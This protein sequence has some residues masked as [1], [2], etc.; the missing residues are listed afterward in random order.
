MTA[1][2]QGEVLRTHSAGLLRRRVSAGPS[3]SGPG[4]R[5]G[6]E[7]RTADMRL[8][9]SR[10]ALR[11]HCPQLGPPSWLRPVLSESATPNPSPGPHRRSSVPSTVQPPPG[12]RAG[13]RIR[14][15]AADA[16]PRRKA[17]LRL[18]FCAPARRDSAA[19]LARQVRLGSSGPPG[20]DS[21][22]AI[23]RLTGTKSSESSFG[24]RWPAELP[25]RTWSPAAPPAPS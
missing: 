6:V 15:S 18:P 14:G 4:C 22:A 1:R 10:T 11:R 13:P 17:A 2:P 25:S 24:P 7:P 23:A 21:E 20:L 16:A 8:G 19:P 3:C 9:R 5:P 12:P